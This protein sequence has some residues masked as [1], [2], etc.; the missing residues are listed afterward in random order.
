[1][2]VR[3]MTDVLGLSMSKQNSR[4]IRRRGYVRLLCTKKDMEQPR[5]KRGI[6]TTHTSYT[7]HS[8]SFQ[9]PPS[10]PTRTFS[11]KFRTRMNLSAA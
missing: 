11:S 4:V 3:D 9:C 5:T 8:A 2:R 6:S 1:M 10:P 7:A